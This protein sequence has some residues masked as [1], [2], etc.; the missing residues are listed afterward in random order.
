M[1]WAPGAAQRAGPARCSL[2]VGQQVRVIE[3]AMMMHVP[4]QKKGFE[5]KGSVGTVIR[6]YSEP[7]LSPNRGVKVEFQEPKKWVA[8]FESWELEPVD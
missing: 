8:H 2:K 6:T 1:R 5:A 4:G 3:E 7:N